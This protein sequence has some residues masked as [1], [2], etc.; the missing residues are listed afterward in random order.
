M[1][2]CSCHG[3]KC[4]NRT[5]AWN[6]FEDITHPCSSYQSW[7]K[8]TAKVNMG[9]AKVWRKN[10]FFGED[11][12]FHVKEFSTALINILYILYFYN[13]VYIVFSTVVSWCPAWSKTQ[14][15]WEFYPP[16][17]WARQQVSIAL[18]E[19][20]V[21][22]FQQARDANRKG[23]AGRN[24]CCQCLLSQFGLLKCGTRW[25]LKIL[26]MAVGSSQKA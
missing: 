12:V 16:Y 4:D 15:W 25:F 22:Y 5:D 26:K 24:L 2:K 14:L 17:E 23:L 20:V 10:T 8:C 18:I 9:F 13:T 1:F 3:M 21:A 11:D 19:R 7:P 6:K